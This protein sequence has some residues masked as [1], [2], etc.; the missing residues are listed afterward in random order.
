MLAPAMQPAAPTR[1]LVAW[2]LYDWANSAFPTVVTTFVFAAYFTQAVAASPELGTAQWSRAQSLAALAVALL[3]PVLGAIADRGGSRKPWL[4]ALTLLSIA[5]TALLWFVHPHP[6]HAGRALVLVA[7][8]TVGFELASVFYN[9]MLPALAPREAVGRWSGWGWGLGYAGGLASL[10]VCLVGFIQTDAPWFGLG[11]AE[12]ANVRATA[13]VVAVWFAVFALPLFLLVR[14]PPAPSLPL[15]AATRAGLRTLAQTLREVRKHRV[16]MLF[17]LAQMLYADGL[18]TLFAFGG[19]Y[20][21][22]TF[23]M[24]LAEVIQFGILLNVTAGLGAACFARLDD[25]LG[26]RPVIVFSLLAL[27]ASGAAAVLVESKTAFWI[28][29]ALLGVFVGPVQAASRSM[30]ARLAPPDMRGE[31]F[32]LLALSGKATAFLGPAALGAATLYFE[33]QRAGM[34][35]ILLFWLAGLIL[36]LGVRDA[37]AAVSAGNGA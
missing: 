15:V 6:G 1:D 23:G 10:V 25:R 19:I 35:T 34:A 29:G 5:A 20:A 7:L 11:K 26:A 31:M 2:S 28:L 21:A 14:E 27:L 12:A 37:R 36:L 17:L 13:L 9:A 3:S 8:A 4:L 30:V 32:G 16:L 24:A 18:V 33:S 22:G